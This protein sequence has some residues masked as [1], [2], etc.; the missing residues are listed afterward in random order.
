[1]TLMEWLNQQFGELDAVIRRGAMIALMVYLV[2]KIVKTGG[3]LGSII[4]ALVAC[5]LIWWGI[6][7]GFTDLSEMWGNMTSANTEGE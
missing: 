7:G 6:E 4:V 1:M 2:F 5:S 3:G